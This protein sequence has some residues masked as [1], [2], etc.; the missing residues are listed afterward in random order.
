M[1]KFAG[2][3]AGQ[4]ADKGLFITTA[5]FTREALAFP[6]KQ[7]AARIVLVGGR[8]LTQLMIEY[9]LGVTVQDTFSIKHLDVDSF[10][11]D[12]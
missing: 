8:Q 10:D 12:A 6:A 9:N 2:A 4:G 1:Q 11:P 5:R 7:H 3:L